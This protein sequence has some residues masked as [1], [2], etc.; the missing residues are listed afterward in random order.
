MLLKNSNGA[1]NLNCGSE[2]IRDAWAEAIQYD[3]DRLDRKG[4]A[5]AAVRA[6]AFSDVG[7]RR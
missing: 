7:Q 3:I 1:L 5:T 6:E 4:E 2:D